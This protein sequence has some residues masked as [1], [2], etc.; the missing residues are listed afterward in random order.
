MCIICV[1]DKGV[2]QPNEA[3]IRRMFQR[4]PHGAGYMVAEG[5]GVRIEK[6]FMNV[7]ELLRSL[8]SEKFTEDDVVV[9]HFRIS[10]QAGV[11]PEMTQ[12]FPLCENL[13][14]MKYLSTI[15]DCGVAH[16]GI[17]RLTTDPT[18]VEYSD[19]AL[20]ISFYLTEMVKGSAS[21]RDQKTLDKIAE[22]IQSKMVLLDKFGNMALIGQ[23]IE[24]DGLMFSNS[25]YEGYKQFTLDDVKH[26]R[27][28]L[29]KELQELM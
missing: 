19:T 26:W 1:S 20:F 4:N 6:G 5:D 12:P 7:T 14:S 17:I 22:L 23:F 11:N 8:R 28:T 15:A 25:S 10:T 29:D 2:R 24:H 21:L 3:E 13:E 27:R 9:Y 16:N 18:E